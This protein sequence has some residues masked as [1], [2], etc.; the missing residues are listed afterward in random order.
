[1]LSN[2]GTVER[3]SERPFPVEYVGRRSIA[4][5]KMRLQIEFYLQL[6]L[7]GAS[8]NK[9]TEDEEEVDREIS[10][11]CQTREIEAR[12]EVFQQTCISVSSRLASFD[13]T[14][15]CPPLHLDV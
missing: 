2:L 7:L 3:V 6:S 13:F 8:N 10:V 15:Q 12:L 9:G 14:A 4:F 5:G 1:M 11:W